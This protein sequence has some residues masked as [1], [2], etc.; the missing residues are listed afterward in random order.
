MKNTEIL[1]LINAMEGFRL[2][3]RE[4]H[5]STR[6]NSIHK[7]CDDIMA[8]LHDKSDEIAEDAQGMFGRIEIGQLKPTEPA[9]K[10]LI[11]M[12]R[13]LRTICMSAKEKWTDKRFSG[14]S[15]ILDDLIHDANKWT[16]L[17]TFG[18][19]KA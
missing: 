11:P 6:R 10:D 2:R 7:L 19:D 15:S 9:E 8:E 3:T 17:A 1:E 13:A 14:I 4:I 12:L 16:Y 18:D 5:W